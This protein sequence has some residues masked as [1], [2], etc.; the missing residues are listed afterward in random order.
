M[1]RPE[2]VMMGPHENIQA[3]LR[4]FQTGTAS[5]DRQRHHASIARGFWCFCLAPSIRK[6]IRSIRLIRGRILSR[7]QVFIFV[8][9]LAM[10]AKTWRGDDGADWK[11]PS[12]LEDFQ[13]GTASMARKRHLASSARGF[14]CFCLMAQIEVQEVQEVQIR[15]IRQIRGRKEIKSKAVCPVII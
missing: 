9:R 5:M 8:Y 11:Y 10:D 15:S 12:L 4:D 1:Q 7:G 3:C 14:Y 13:T 6:L 2:W